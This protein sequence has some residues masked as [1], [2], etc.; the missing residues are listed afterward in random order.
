MKVIQIPGGTAS[1]RERGKDEIPGRA[2]KLIRA[3]TMSAMSALSDYPEIFE[4][5][6]KGESDDD[7]TERLNERLKGVLLSTQQAMIWD[8]VREATVVGLLASWSLERPLPTLD[9]IGDLP[10]DLY[11]AL[12]DEVGGVSAA[13]LQEDFEMSDPKA[14]GYKERP[15][16]D[17]SGS[18]KP[19]EA[20]QPK[21]S[22]PKLQSVGEST[23]SASSIPA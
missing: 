10:E 18:E 9:T 17:S 6:R 15:T 4:G 12:L 22:T 19:S 5:P 2:I 11:L 23:P 14:P 3:A 7:R 20:A 8:N 21:E 13:D 1:F 16:I